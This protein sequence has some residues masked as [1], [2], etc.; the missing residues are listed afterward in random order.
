MEIPSKGIFRNKRSTY[1]RARRVHCSSYFRPFY[2]KW[3]K[4]CGL[5]VEMDWSVPLTSEYVQISTCI[6]RMIKQKRSVQRA[7]ELSPWGRKWP[8][9]STDHRVHHWRDTVVR[10][11]AKCHSSTFQKFSFI[12][13]FTICKNMVKLRKNIWPSL[14]R[15]IHNNW[16]KSLVTDWPYLRIWWKVTACCSVRWHIW[17]MVCAV[18]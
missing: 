2:P 12:F 17:Q 7:K 8:L 16:N 6:P 10:K 15:L 3:P 18:F 4:K 9:I 11:R 13:F 1:W 5:R 14:R